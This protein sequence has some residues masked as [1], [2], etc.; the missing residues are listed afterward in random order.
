MMFP[1]IN[2]FLNLLMKFGRDRK[3]FSLSFYPETKQ[4]HRMLFPSLT[5]FAACSP[6]R[7]AGQTNR[8]FHKVRKLAE[9]LF[10][11]RKYTHRFI[12]VCLQTY[13]ITQDMCLSRVSEKFLAL[14][15]E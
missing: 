9:K 3:Y 7:T 6:A 8:A 4:I 1:V 14:F 5:P 15:M 12:R 11:A 2:K 13:N 10:L